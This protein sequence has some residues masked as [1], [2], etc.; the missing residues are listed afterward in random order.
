MRDQRKEIGEDWRERERDLKN[1]S[2]I[3]KFQQQERRGNRGIE[4][5]RENKIKINDK[6]CKKI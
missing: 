3:Y 4:K 2:K 5:D 6:Q 1:H